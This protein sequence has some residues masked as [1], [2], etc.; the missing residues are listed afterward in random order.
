MCRVFANGLEDQALIP[1]RVIPKK[2]TKSDATLLIIEQYTVKTKGK[3]G[4][5]KEIS[6]TFPNSWLL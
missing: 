6:S 1:D 3:V 5:S 2:K 4:Q